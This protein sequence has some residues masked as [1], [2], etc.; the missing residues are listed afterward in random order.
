MAFAF[1]KHGEQKRKYTGE[2]YMK[3]LEEV[4]NLVNMAEHTYCVQLAWL[5]DVLEDTN[6]TY[7]ELFVEFGREIADDV[8]VLSDLLKPED[9]NRAYRKAKYKEQ[10]ADAH[11]GVQTVKLA[12]L[13][14]NTSSIVLHDPAFAKVYLR[15]KKELLDVLTR[16]NK[17]LHWIASNMVEIGLRALV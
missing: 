2:P 12:D 15:E 1:E 14:S 4:V 13:I 3:H 6:A 11:K 8:R 5:H 7:Q 17:T 10:L 9:G 16:G